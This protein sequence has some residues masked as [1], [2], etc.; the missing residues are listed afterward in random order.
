MGNMTM[1]NILRSEGSSK[2]SMLG[3]AAG[4]VLN[5]ALDHCLSLPLAGVFQVQVATALSQVFLL[6]LL[7]HYLM[8]RSVLSIKLSNF[9]PSLAMYKEIFKVGIP[10][11]LR[12][13]L[14]SI[15]IWFFK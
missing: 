13:T 9:K 10:T 14:F 5:V 11:F 2:L 6:I 3:M 12:Q 1:N 8:K 4:S 15:T 7:S